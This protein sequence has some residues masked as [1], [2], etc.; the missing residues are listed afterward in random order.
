MELLKHIEGFLKKTAMA[1]TRFG[2]EVAGDPRLVGDMRAGREPRPDL[3]S[4]IRTY[5]QQNGG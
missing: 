2:R 5:I 4:R 1:P 3:Q